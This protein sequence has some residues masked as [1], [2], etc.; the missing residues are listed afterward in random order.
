MRRLRSSVRCSMR[1]MP[2]SSARSVTALRALSM[3]SRSA[4]LGGLA[5]CVLGCDGIVFGI[6]RNRFEYRRERGVAYGKAGG[7][8][9]KIQ[10]A[11]CGDGERFRLLRS[12]VR[13]LVMELFN[14]GA[15]RGDGVLAAVGDGRCIYN[16]S[17][18]GICLHRGDLFPLLFLVG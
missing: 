6:V 12:Q 10:V 9:H 5:V 15:E 17:Y 1:L 13:M 4:T 16:R 2:G 18:W 11:G 3:E 8:W 7:G 14:A